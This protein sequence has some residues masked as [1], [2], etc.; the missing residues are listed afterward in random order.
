MIPLAMLVCHCH[1]ITDRTIRQ[2]VREGAAS[3]AQVIRRC[4]AGSH[5]G[6]CRPRIRELVREE[7]AARATAGADD[8]LVVVSAPTPQLAPTG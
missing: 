7:L 6:G 4:R 2:Q 3:P 5:C 1:G 8:S